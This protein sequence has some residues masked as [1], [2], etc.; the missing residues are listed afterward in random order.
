MRE[1]SVV[2]GVYGAQLPDIDGPEPQAV[3]RTTTGTRR[4]IWRPPVPELLERRPV[5]IRRS[6]GMPSLEAAHAQR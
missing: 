2:A 6:G 3:R 5:Q 1:A 4:S